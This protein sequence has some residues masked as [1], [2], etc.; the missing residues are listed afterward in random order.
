MGLN[1]FLEKLGK[2]PEQITSELGG[3]PGAF[4]DIF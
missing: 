3:A 4:D 1:A 2:T